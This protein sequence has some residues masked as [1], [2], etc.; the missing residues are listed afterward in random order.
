MATPERLQELANAS[1]PRIQLVA[2]FFLW[3][4]PDVTEIL[5]VRH[6]QVSEGPIGADPSLTDL[7]REQAEALAA[8]LATMR[9]DGVY[10]SPSN[11]ARETAAAVAG[12]HGLGVEVI[13]ALD[14]LHNSMPRGATPLEA[15]VQAFGEEEGNRRYEA[16]VRGGWSLDLFGGLLESSAS[17]RGRVIAAVDAVVA[18]HPGERA[19]VVS[20]GPPIAAYAGHVL[21]SPADFAYYPRLTSITL[22]LAKGDRR[23]THVL[24]ATPHFGCL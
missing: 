15:L 3:P 9:I 8:Y 23:Q 13:A 18:S 14:D 24:N 11:R 21:G 7:G 6:A 1:E 10:A 19:V 5:L 17:L 12:R 2:P 22:V 16:M 4:G 20:H